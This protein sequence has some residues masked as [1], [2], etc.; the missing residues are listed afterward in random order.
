MSPAQTFAL[1]V[2][3]HIGA[4]L[5]ALALLWVTSPQVFKR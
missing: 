2:G 5:V 3:V 4:V 1:F